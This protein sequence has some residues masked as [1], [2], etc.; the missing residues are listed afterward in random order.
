[1]NKYFIKTTF[2]IVLFLFNSTG[3]LSQK[4]SQ[5]T[6]S[7]TMNVSQKKDKELVEGWNRL[8]EKGLKILY[9]GIKV[10]K[11]DSVKAFLYYQAGE[12]QT[13]LGNF[14]E[15]IDD[16][17]YSINLVPIEI[18]Y[19]KRAQSY[20]YLNQFG[21][22]IN[23]IDSQIDLLKKVKKLKYSSLEEANFNCSLFKGIAYYRLN[24]LDKASEVFSY[25]IDNIKNFHDDYKIY[26][27]RANISIEQNKVKE[28]IYDLTNAIF[29]SK[30]KDQDTYKSALYTRADLR[31]SIGDN[32]GAIIDLD[33]VLNLDSSNIESIVLRSEVYFKMGNINLALVNANQA[34]T[35]NNKDI[36]AL[37]VRGKCKIN[38]KD[39]K[40]GCLDFSRAGELGSDNAWELIKLNCQ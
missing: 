27:L 24:N 6:I 21:Y 7:D 8:F 26:K 19:L 35:L 4:L 39:L 30:D 20:F 37:I 16:F 3:V 36:N 17:N 32:Y 12:L 9:D 31:S 2:L 40:G 18:V 38:L 11:N 29:L 13:K 1:M 28:A 22:A 34:L 5:N 33:K 10:A 14:K 23:D 25:Y 15:S